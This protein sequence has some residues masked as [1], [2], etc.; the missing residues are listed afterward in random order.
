MSDDVIDVLVYIPIVIIFSMMS[1]IY[2]LWKYANRR[3]FPWH[4]YITISV[5][6]FCAFS[7]ILLVPL[8]LAITIT[9]R[10]SNTEKLY[11]DDNFKV[12]INTYLVLYW[13]TTI[14]GSMI[15]VI[16]EQYNSNG[17]FT[18]LTKIRNSLKQLSLKLMALIIC[19][20]IFF[21][22]LIGS[23]AVKTNS[24]AILLTSILLTSTVWISFLMLLLGYG[25]IMFP[26]TIWQRCNFEQRLIRIQ[27]EIAQEFENVT[28]AYS[29]IFLCISNIQK[30]QKEINNMVPV[31]KQLVDAMKILIEDSPV[32]INCSDN[33]NVIINKQ[34]D[35]IT[36]GALADYRE[37]LYC[38]SAIFTASQGKLNKLQ[39]KAYFLED[40]IDATGTLGE[41]ESK[42]LGYSHINWSF[43]PKG[44]YYEFL[45]HIKI[46]PILYKLVSIICAV[47]SFCTYLCIVSTI[48]GVP[49]YVSPYF[50]VV[51]NDISQLDIVVFTFITI[52]YTCYV[53][54]WALFEIKLFKSLELVRNKVTWPIPM[55]TNAIIFA[56]LAAPLSFFY[57]GL[58]HENGIVDS[59]FEIDVNGERLNTIFS[60]FYQINAIPIIGSKSNAFFPSLIIC[61]SL[62]TIG[63]LLNTLLKTIHCSE[64]QFGQLDVSNDVLEE[65]KVKLSKRKKLIKKAYRKILKQTD[66]SGD[67]DYFNSF[68][69]G[70]FQKSKFHCE[71]L[72]NDED[73]EENSESDCLNNSSLSITDPQK[74]N[75]DN[76][77]KRIGSFSNM[78]KKYSIRVADE[79]CIE[80]V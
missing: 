1:S 8:D 18:V 41:I 43:K 69:K 3:V 73:N 51:H 75:I 38:N 24:K 14:L 46:K 64:L 35:D 49:L 32:D 45:W 6:Y 39:M 29:D 44:S 61:V 62:L 65:G 19:G 66:K 54:R 74:P 40:L 30:T 60:N 15:M 12:I 13:T 27:H 10:R 25:F 11:Y 52:G 67:E 5:Q 72:L 21:G 48:D 31:N 70:F 78:F 34:N 57:L 16:E 68:F 2:L 22:I 20:S 53:A 79:K 37:K 80:N 4:T 63:N 77:K 55:S 76:I 42:I 59:N 33:G 58:L 17:F 23:D 7:I 28:H 47:L 71:I 26:V 56:S 50:V 9:G 36:I